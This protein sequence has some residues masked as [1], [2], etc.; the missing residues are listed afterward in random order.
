MKI[1]TGCLEEKPL[2]LFS[3]NKARRDG[4]QS[5]CKACLYAYETSPSGQA[6][7]R[8]YR[9]GPKGKLRS[10][11]F[12]AS[13][14][15]IAAQKKYAASP[16]GRASA[17]KGEAR[18]RASPKGRAYA[19]A[20]A[21][22]PSRKAYEAAWK[23]NNKPLLSAYAM[24]YVSTKLRAMPRWV[25]K[26]DF[27]PFYEKAAQLTAITGVEHHVDHIVPLR[28]RD[29]CGLHVPYNLQVITKSENSRKNNRLLDF[30]PGPT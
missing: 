3:K 14:K 15:G 23:E 9:L 29:V 10:R 19:R 8:K 4:H 24:R 7:A 6:A 30:F 17:S 12:A 22:R 27:R 21:L 13:P 26:D 20:Y 11:R 5:R 28:G 1:C 16:K 2:S 25:N 18:Y